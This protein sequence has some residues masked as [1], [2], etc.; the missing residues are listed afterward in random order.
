MSGKTKLP[1]PAAIRADALDLYED[2]AKTTGET[3]L[4]PI[5]ATKTLAERYGVGTDRVASPVAATYYRENGTRN[6]LPVK[7]DAGKGALVSAVRKRRDYPGVGSDGRATLGRWET[8]AA[9]AAAALGRRVS[10]SAV[11][12]LYGADRESY[13]GRGTLAGAPGLRDSAADAL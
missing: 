1:A 12:D 7:A 2:E 9:S 11:R 6:P 10:V 8:V 3:I 5:G 13:V 4:S